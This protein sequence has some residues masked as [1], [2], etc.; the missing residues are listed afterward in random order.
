LDTH[1]EEGGRHDADIL[2]RGGA[3]NQEDDVAEGRCRVSA[4]EPAAHRNV[5]HPLHR[6]LRLGQGG[7]HTEQD[8]QKRDEE[9]KSE[10]VED[11]REDRCRQAPDKRPAVRPEVHEQPLVAAHLSGL[12][13]A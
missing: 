10:S 8:A 13:A 7:A 6:R 12:G 4:E 9:G 5:H 3:E 2:Q 11:R 1:T